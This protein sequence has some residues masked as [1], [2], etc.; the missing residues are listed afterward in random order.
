[1]CIILHPCYHEPHTSGQN[2]FSLHISCCTYTPVVS[3]LN[4]STLST[5]ICLQCAPNSPVCNGPVWLN[6][7]MPI[8]Y[9]VLGID[10]FTMLGMRRTSN[11]ECLLWLPFCT[12]SII[13]SPSVIHA[14][15]FFPR[16]LLRQHIHHHSTRLCHLSLLCGLRAFD[17]TQWPTHFRAPSS[18]SRASRPRR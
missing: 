7:T 11:F 18:A 17:Q 10:N 2:I 16:L 13:R 5:Y 12:Q 14:T 4:S 9:Y 8:D 6:S 15:H 1:M 3:C